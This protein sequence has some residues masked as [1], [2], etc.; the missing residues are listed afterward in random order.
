MH[1]GGIWVYMHVVWTYELALCEILCLLKPH[2]GRLVVIPTA[3]TPAG[4][5]GVGVGVRVCVTVNAE[6]STVK[7]NTKTHASQHANTI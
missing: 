1:V 2:T 4:R 3:Y 6:S 5:R 7:T